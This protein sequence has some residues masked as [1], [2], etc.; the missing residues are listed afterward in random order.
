[1]DT[2]DCNAERAYGLVWLAGLSIS[3]NLSSQGMMQFRKGQPH[4]AY[5]LN[6]M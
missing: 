2:P 4:G 6:L 1:M 5:F 3:A